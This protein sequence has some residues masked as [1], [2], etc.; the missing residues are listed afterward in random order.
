MDKKVTLLDFWASWCGPCRVMHPIVEEIAKDYGDKLEIKKYN[1]D[2]TENQP[3]MEKY[4]VQAMPTFFIL[5]N[6]EV[7]E[8]LVGAQSKTVLRAAIDKALG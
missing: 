3:L 8:Q 5:K 4:Q 1:V 7:V 6:G 2:E